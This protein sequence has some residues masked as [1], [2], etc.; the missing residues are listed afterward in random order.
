MRQSRLINDQ[1]DLAARQLAIE[2]YRNDI[3]DSADHPEVAARRLERLRRQWAN[4]CK[5][6]A[7]DLKRL[8][9]LLKAESARL[10]LRFAE[11]QH[12][13]T[14]LQN[15]VGDLE[16]L[17]SVAEI[18]QVNTAAERAQ[19]IE[20]ATAEAQQR[21]SY[22]RQLATLREQIDHLAALFIEPPAVQDFRAA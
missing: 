5:A 8:S 9:A 1:Q 18:Q 12:E 20:Q 7:R 15:R 6:G 17:F 19:R 11:L 22:E 16:D 14:K 13:E 3:I 2:Q 21:A 4:R 10:D